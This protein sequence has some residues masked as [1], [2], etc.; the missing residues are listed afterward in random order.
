[1]T[2]ACPPAPPPPLS[3]LRRFRRDEEGAVLAEFLILLP[4]LIWAF[5]AL[6]IYWDAF[7]TINQGQK[8]SY[9]VADLMARQS[10]VTPQFVDGMANVMA[11]LTP[12]SP[13]VRLR[14]SSIEWREATRA[15][16]VLFSRSPSNRLPEL[17]AADFLSIRHRIPDMADGDS[18]LVIETMID[19]QPAMDVGLP[20]S[21][22]QNF[23]IMRPRYF[24][25]V[26]LTTAPCPAQI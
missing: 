19:Y 8:A 2:H 9:A 12:A 6:F 17:R 3:R 13:R 16:R 5:L 14:I 7:R 4:L 15:Y 26:C 21:I 20:R 10:D 1:M 22:A 11:F 23:I 24:R 18:V 25:R